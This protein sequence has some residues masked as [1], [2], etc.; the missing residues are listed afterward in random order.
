M[1]RSK[2]YNCTENEMIVLISY[3]VFPAERFTRARG[4]IFVIFLLCDVTSSF[5]E[6]LRTCILRRSEKV[7]LRKLTLDLLKLFRLETGKRYF[8][9]FC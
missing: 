7:K 8:L 4:F 9:R 3:F 2:E 1:I 5:L 6:L